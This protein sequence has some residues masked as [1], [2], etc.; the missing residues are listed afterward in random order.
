M[1]LNDDY[2]T[3]IADILRQPDP[4][5]ALEERL[6]DGRT[7]AALRELLSGLDGDGLR[8]S[9][10]L[11]MQLRFSRLLNG[12]GQAAAD[13]EVDPRAFSLRFRC[14]HA[15]VPPE[16]DDPLAEAASYRAWKDGL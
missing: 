11:V 14:Y 16:A 15:E 3:A 10:L 6:E 9:A 1:S 2:V 7:S 12:S 4:V 5:D 8:M 13:F